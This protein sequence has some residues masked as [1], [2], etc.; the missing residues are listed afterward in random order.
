MRT[1]R[2]AALIE[3]EP[4]PHELWT[5]RTMAS[6]GCELRVMRAAPARGGRSLERGPLNALS[7]VIGGAVASRVAAEERE[8]LEELFD[9]E[10]LRAWWTGSGIAPV[11][12]EALNHA[13]AQAALSAMPPDVIVRVSGGMPASRISSLA[14]FAA[15]NIHYGRAP[16]IHGR[17]SIPWGILEGRREWI[18]AT[19]H[20]IDGESE[21]G[22]ILWRGGPQLAPGDT[23]VDLFF[24]AHLEAAD[25]LVRLLN[26]Y[27]RGDI[28]RLCVPS[29]GE[30]ST[31]RSSAGLREWLMLLYLDRGRR[32][33]VLL[34]RGLEC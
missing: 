19:V 14:K 18:G 34:E 10:D 17:W 16:L 12:V 7:R 9:F 1:L 6:A 20:L 30:V 4:G 13:Q 22:P 26:A 2:V 29:A 25:A 11:E 24:R 33:R 21:T 5:L 31:Y 8:I 27:A 3:G 23:H 32:A 28:P 15:L